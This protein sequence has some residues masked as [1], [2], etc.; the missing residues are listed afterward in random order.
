[1]LKLVVHIVTTKLDFSWLH[2]PS[3]PRSPH[4]RGFEIILRNTALGL[5]LDLYLITHNTDDSM[6]PAE[7]E[8]E[9]PARE[10]PQT[11]ALN[12]AATGTP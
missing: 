6:P 7:F 1:M 8:T 10:G 9:F 5:T 11:H 12:C 3:G 2:S 4:C